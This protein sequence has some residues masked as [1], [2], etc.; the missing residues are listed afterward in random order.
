VRCAGE[1]SEARRSDSSSEVRV[2]TEV[3]N[4]EAEI[5]ENELAGCHLR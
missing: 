5:F 3:K 4:S 2:T 1:K